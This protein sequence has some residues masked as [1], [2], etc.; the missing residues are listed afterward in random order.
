MKIH[1]EDLIIK[2]DRDS[3]DTDHPYKK[4]GHTV[5]VKHSLT[6]ITSIKHNTSCLIAFSEAVKEIEEQLNKI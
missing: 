4:R 1:R 2:V 5:I 6:G 3:Y